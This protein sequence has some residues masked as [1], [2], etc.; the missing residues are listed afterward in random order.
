MPLDLSGYWK[1]T[2]NENFEEF[3]KALDIN[4][5]IR[6]I[7][8]LLR[9]D[10]EIIQ[11]GDHMVIKTLSTFR[12]YNMEF[13]LGKEFF[14]DLAAVDGRKCMTTINWEGDKLVCVQKGEI[15]GRGWTHWMEGDQ[16]YLE[17]RAGGV[18]CKQSFKKT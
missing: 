14:E 6:K 5:A 3:M 9:P 7:A 18:A 8:R 10:K 13:D 17:L 1:M 11:N 2:S 12:N 16:L 15:E 4:I